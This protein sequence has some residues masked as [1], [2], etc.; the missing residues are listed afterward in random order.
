MYDPLLEHNQTKRKV[1]A[2]NNAKR[3]QDQLLGSK[4]PR[5][6][7]LLKEDLYNNLKNLMENRKIELFNDPRITQSLRSIQYEN[8]EGQLKI[9]G[10]YSHIVEALIRACYCM[11]DKGL[12][13]YIY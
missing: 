8:T 6:K 3:S 13:I 5:K 2:I 12:N 10:N 11:K 9:Y 7:V 4:T 1:V